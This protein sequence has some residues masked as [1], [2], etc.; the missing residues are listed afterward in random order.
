MNSES[1]KFNSIRNIIFGYANQIITLLL[2]FVGRTVFIKILGEDYLGINGLFSDVL[3][4]LSMA[5]LGFGT[6]MTYS[7]YKPVAE[8]DE[9][10]IAAL[11]HFYK[12]IYNFIALTVAVIGVMLIPF[13]KYLVNLDQGIPYLKIY[14]L[15]FLANTVISYLF[16]YKT[17][18]INASQKNYLISTYQAVVNMVKTILQ[19]ITLLL[20]HNYFVYLFLT[21]AA[22]LANNL[23]ASYK[24]DQLYPE[25][26]K[27]K[28][29]LVPEEK[30]SIFENMK[31]IFLYKV[32]GV[33][34]NGTDNTLISIIV[35]TVWVGIYSN[36]NM[37]ITAV[38]GFI[39]T[40]FSSVTAS[41][42]N[43]V[44]TEKSQKRYEV[45]KVMQLISLAIAA[46]T[47]VVMYT[48]MNDLVNVWLGEKFVLTGN[49]LIAIMC[50]FYLANI[51]RPIWSYREATGLYMQ[52]RYIMLIAAA[53]NL[54]LSVILGK[55]FG[56]VGIL[57]ASA[58]SRLVTYFWYEPKLLF[59]NYF[60]ESVKDFYLSIIK[61]IILVVCLCLIILWGG[62][63]FYIDTW[64]KLF[65][66]AVVVAVI[67]AVGV[68]CAYIR[69]DEFKMIWEMVSRIIM[70]I[71]SHKG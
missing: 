53:V 3:M 44:V 28:A 5:D 63:K 47:T 11:I 49:I 19:I 33:L 22:T 60:E 71:R 27:G 69:T 61:N 13:L 48:L 40:L 6:A 16:V 41:I 52:T 26:R 25:I 55:I 37:V 14:Y 35:G 10:K 50:N 43:V 8:H 64:A 18:I 54:A 68:L 66:K 2:S 24:A 23:I 31:S 46:W 9:K 36:Y 34:L 57:A 59:K 32:S 7:F 38:N 20:F 45:F 62:Q 17:S 15:F 29:E 70:K 56:M 30:K 1:R 67:A 51:L 21:I 39:N 12:K 4:M 58:I 65:V 42:G